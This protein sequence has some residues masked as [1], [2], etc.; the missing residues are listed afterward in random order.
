M[1]AGFGVIG[2][3]VRDPA[4]HD[5][6]TVRDLLFDDGGRR[7]IAVVTERGRLRRTRQF[8]PFEQIWE[9]HKDRVIVDDDP[10][11][12]CSERPAA[13]ADTLEGKAVV[14]RS[15][16]Y[17]GIVDDIYFDETT[18]DV[19][20]YQVRPPSR[21]G[22]RDRSLLLVDAPP[23]VGDVIVVPDAHLQEWRAL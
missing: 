5:L 18:G 19:R 2:L 17:V 21:R 13:V 1:T 16:R 15:G 20:A 7:L 4:G 6:G 22:R 23:A 11:R 3:P 9:I 8:V 14:S 10:A 12:R